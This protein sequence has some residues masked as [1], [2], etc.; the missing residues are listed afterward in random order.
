MWQVPKG[1]DAC[2]HIL[3]VMMKNDITKIPEKYIIDRW[4][5]KEYNMSKKTEV[6]AGGPQSVKSKEH[7]EI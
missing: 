4:K 5:M 6:R 2:C 7:V 1:W 3:K